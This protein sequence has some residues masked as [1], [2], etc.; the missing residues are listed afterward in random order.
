[1]ADDDVHDRSPAWGT[2]PE[3]SVSCVDGAIQTYSQQ[4]ENVQQN[5]TTLPPKALS[6]TPELKPNDDV[7]GVDILNTA[8]QN[9]AKAFDT[10][11]GGIGQAPKYPTTR[12]SS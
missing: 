12:I 7:P 8:L 4:P 6:T 3:G 2:F 9:L 5:V 1:M 10:E 11:W